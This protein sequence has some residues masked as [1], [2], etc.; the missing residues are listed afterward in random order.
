MDP[1]ALRDREVDVDLES[2][3]AVDKNENGATDYISLI[4]PNEV[5]DSKLLSPE[6]A[7]AGKTPGSPERKEATKEKHKKT[8][9]KKPPRPPRPPR[10]PSFDSADQKLIKEIAELA[11]L[12]KARVERMRALKKAKNSK[13][14]SS[15]N[16][17]VIALVFTLIFFLMVIFQGISPNRESLLASVEGPS[18]EAAGGLISVQYY[19]T[20][21]LNY[22]NPLEDST[23]NL[24]HKV[25]VADAR[26]ESS[27]RVV[28]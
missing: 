16:N 2:G 1:I 24:V 13:T 21:A 25:A 15:S 11:M 18:P 20:S 27:N 19:P 10:G 3:W 6:R 12:K 22:V 8:S 23:H 5:K 17:T 7:E 14:S 28:G 9:S 4:N 26:E